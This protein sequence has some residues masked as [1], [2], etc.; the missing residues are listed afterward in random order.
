[1]RNHRLLRAIAGKDRGDR[2]LGKYSGSSSSIS[3][4]AGRC[5]RGRRRPVIAGRPSGKISLVTQDL[6]P[7]D[8]R[9]RGRQG[10]GLCDDT[11][12]R[13][14]E[15]Y[16]HLFTS[17]RALSIFLVPSPRVR[18]PGVRLTFARRSSADCLETWRSC[19]AFAWCRRSWLEDFRRR[20][21]VIPFILQLRLTLIFWMQ[22]A[23][24]RRSFK[25]RA[26]RACRT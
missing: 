3:A 25:H 15:L 12:T 10:L 19:A 8:R 26:L 21:A 11:S 14:F 6:L 22:I 18:V 20:I 2:S 24:L 5:T 16:T 9:L 1:M 23:P 7:I 13:P 4:G 17:Y